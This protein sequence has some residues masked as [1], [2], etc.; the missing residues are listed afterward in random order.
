MQQIGF[1]KSVSN[2]DQVEQSMKAAVAKVAPVWPLDRFV[3]VNPY[4]GQTHLPFEQVASELSALNNQNLAMPK[5]YYLAQLAEGKMEKQDL[6][7]ALKRHNHPALDPEAFLAELEKGETPNITT[8]SV[9]QALETIGGIELH[10]LMVSRVSTWAAS[11][12]DQGQA[13]VRA[14][15]SRG[16]FAGWKFEAERDLAPEI[17]GLHGF[18]KAVQKLPNE[19][20]EAV[21]YGLYVLGLTPSEA[22][23]YFHKLLLDAGGWAAHCARL[24]WEAKLAGNKSSQAFEYLAVLVSWEVCLLEVFHHPDA[25]T[26]WE[27]ERNYLLQATPETKPEW[28]LQ[29]AWDIAAQRELKSKINNS[30][31]SEPIK[32][33]SAQA[34]F[35]I[36]VRSE[37][38]RRN[39]EAVNPTIETLGYAGFF[40]FPVALQPAAGI[41][42]DPQCP[43][44]LSPVATVEEV[45]THEAAT[46]MLHENRSTAAGVLAT[47]RK[48]ATGAVSNFS[49]VSPLGLTFLPTLLLQAFGKRRP[50]QKWETLGLA[51]EQHTQRR[52]SAASGMSYKQ[53]LTLAT[54]ALKTMSLGGSFAPYVLLVG[55]GSHSTNN[56]H[57]SGLDCG[58]CGGH[59]GEANALLA[60]EVFNN[61]EVR[62]GLA[63]N[64]Y[65]IPA[66]TVFLACLHNTTTDEITLLNPEMVSVNGESNWA[67]IERSLQEAGSLTR[68]ERLRR[69]DQEAGKSADEQIMER[70]RDW[71]QVRPEWGLAGCSAFVAAPRRITSL[72]DLEGRA[73]LHSYEPSLDPEGAVLETIMTA[74]MVVASWINLQ[75]YGSAVDPQVYGSGNKLLHNVTS[76]LGVLEGGSGDLRVGLPWQSVHD[77]TNYQHQSNRLMVVL[78]A[79]TQAIDKVLEKHKNVKELFDNQWIYLYSLNEATGKIAHRYAGNGNWTAA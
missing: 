52:V 65:T 47:W 7:E 20:V 55:H 38:Y 76:G 54:N 17:N 75:Y 30:H 2:L 5:D 51:K 53:Q 45:G 29:T 35:C 49:F 16:V 24:D 40:G 77:G 1:K 73:F 34:V 18:R 46:E 14:A 60:A 56:P 64:G 6:Q 72:M 66:N 71:S 4:L 63:E 32:E 69:M 43:V 21:A 70:S 15:S 41:E 11:Y 67:A 8:K 33:C 42:A 39:L 61:S 58:A 44:L 13:K 79:D 10:R 25:K 62:K 78:A 28:I 26:C 50:A 68:Q 57:A 22:G 9:S 19:P 23:R 12:F 59:S 3:A 48:F 37:V 36:D 31:P 27:E 74:P